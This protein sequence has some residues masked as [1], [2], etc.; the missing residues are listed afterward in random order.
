MGRMIQIGNRNYQIVGLFERKGSAMGGSNDNFVMI[1]L[2]SFDRQFP[3]VAHGGDT[4]HIATLPKSP[5]HFYQAI[6]QGTAVLRARRKL[7][8]HEPNDFAIYTP[9]KLIQQTKGIFF[10]KEVRVISFIQP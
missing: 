7:K 4:I 9:E 10:R 1:P 2:S 3:W 6:E 8:P 5:D